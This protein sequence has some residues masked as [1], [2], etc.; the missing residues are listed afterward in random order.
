MQSTYE[1][2][3]DERVSGLLVGEKVNCRFPQT[4]MGVGF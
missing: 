2:R 1:D 4:H 3:K